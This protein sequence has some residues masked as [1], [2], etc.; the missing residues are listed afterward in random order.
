MDFKA[1]KSNCSHQSASSVGFSGCERENVMET[2]S[3]DGENAMQ[4]FPSLQ[5]VVGIGSSTKKTVILYISRIRK[6]S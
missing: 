4:I 3:T 5:L 6:F 1:V 2:R